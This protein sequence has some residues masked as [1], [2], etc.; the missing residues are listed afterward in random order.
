LQRLGFTLHYEAAAAAVKS[1]AWL[2]GLIALS[3]F[4]QYPA[5]TADS[6]IRSH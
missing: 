4:L 6:A 5:L 2:S 3:R 1:D